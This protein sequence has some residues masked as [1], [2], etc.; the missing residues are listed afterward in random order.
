MKYTNARFPS[1]NTNLLA[2]FK[3]SGQEY[4]TD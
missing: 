1:E 4:L 2:S 3:E